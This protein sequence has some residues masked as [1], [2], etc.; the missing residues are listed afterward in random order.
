MTISTRIV[1][2]SGS[3]YLKMLFGSWAM[4]NWYY[5]VFAILP[6][7]CLSFLNHNFAFVTVMVIFIVI[8]MHL[9]MVY[10]R[11]A[12][13]EEAVVAVRRGLIVISESGIE[14]IFYN[15]EDKVVGSKTYGF[16]DFCDIEDIDGGFRI[17]YKKSKYQFIPFYISD[18]F[19]TDEYYQ[20]KL[21]IAQKLGFEELF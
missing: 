1:K 18:F 14:K 15:N 7:V 10:F 5:F 12:F 11:H 19:D 16:E 9:A 8:P 6:F 13:K 3:S 17:V 21:F 20:A 4:N 2:P